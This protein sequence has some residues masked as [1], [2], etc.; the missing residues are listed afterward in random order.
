MSKRDWLLVL[1]SAS[2]SSTG[3]TG[4]YGFMLKRKGVL[5]E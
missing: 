4:I 1:R 5:Y 3:L 2:Q